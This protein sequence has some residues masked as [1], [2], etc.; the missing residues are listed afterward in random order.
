[1]FVYLIC[2]PV[3]WAVDGKL[4][5]SFHYLPKKHHCD[6]KYWPTEKGVLN[7]FMLAYS[8]LPACNAVMSIHDK[9]KIL[10]SDEQ[11]I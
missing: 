3:Q 11:L 2:T 6:E 10:N 1:M 5:L 4:V 9:Q 8:T 7:C